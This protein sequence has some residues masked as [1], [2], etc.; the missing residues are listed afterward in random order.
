MNYL[1]FINMIHH[2]VPSL[3]CGDPGRLRQILINLLGNA[4]KFT[5]QGEVAVHASLEDEDTSHATIRF[6]ITDTGIGIPRDRI[7]LVFESFSQV[8]AS[9]TRKYGGTGLGLAISKQLVKLMG[10]HIG[11]TSKEGKGS[12]FWFTAVFE[13]QPE[14]RKKAF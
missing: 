9:T 14:D 3:L 7:D 4:I 10:G 8:D 1:E 11:V 5:D 6:G 2:E 13:K 12:E